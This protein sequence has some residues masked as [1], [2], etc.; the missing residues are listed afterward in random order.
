[1]QSSSKSNRVCSL[2]ALALIAVLAMIPATAA[3]AGVQ[4]DSIALTTIG[5]GPQ[6]GILPNQVGWDVDTGYW[7]GSQG[8]AIHAP[9]DQTWTFDRPV[10]LRFGLA[11]LNLGGERFELPPGTT[12]ETIH[13]SH[14]FFADNTEPGVP[15]A[16]TPETPGVPVLGI[17]SSNASAVSTFTLGPVT[18]F[19]L[20]KLGQG[21]AGPAFIEVTYDL[22]EVNISGP[23]DDA[24]YGVGDTVIA[25]YGCVPGT[26]AI[27]TVE[28]DVANG[29][30]ID[31]ST[32]GTYTFTA[33][34]TDEYGAVSTATVE[35]TVAD[36]V[37]VSM[38]NPTVLAA[39]AGLA[40]VV[41]LAARRR[42]QTAD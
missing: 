28:G 9:E 13:A 26:G 18:Q 20:H 6:S 33:I 23:L 21:G 8:Y 16:W 1:M 41:G 22:P 40:L 12:P 3:S 4:T 5:S 19:D 37:G 42:M 25:D 27:D 17:G 14:L 31:T 34:C 2:L 39:G 24:T 11:G 7:A 30:P 29:Q 36:V 38:F 32:P 15:G 35:Y 10:T